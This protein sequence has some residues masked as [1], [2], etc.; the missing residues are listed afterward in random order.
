MSM[1]AIKSDG[2]TRTIVTRGG[3]LFGGGGG[4]TGNG[5]VIEKEEIGCY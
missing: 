1:A 5:G 4:W 3:S 2:W